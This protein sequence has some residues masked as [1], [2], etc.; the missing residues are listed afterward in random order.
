MGSRIVI[1]LQSLLSNDAIRVVLSSERHV[2]DEDAQ[3]Y[4]EDTATVTFEVTAGMAVTEVQ[5]DYTCY[6]GAV[7]L[8]KDFNF[9]RDREHHTK[10]LRLLY[11]HGIN[12]TVQH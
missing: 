10:L 3:P 8:S 2:D 5:F 7:E 6:N 4:T 1:S 11:E 9:F 12:F